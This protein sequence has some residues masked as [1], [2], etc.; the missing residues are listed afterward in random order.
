MKSRKSRTQ[1]SGEDL[2]TWAE[3]RNAP[4]PATLREEPLHD[5]SLTRLRELLKKISGQKP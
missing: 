4:A 5:D 2:W 3:H 1:T